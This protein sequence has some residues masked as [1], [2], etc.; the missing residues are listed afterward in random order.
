[1]TE[2]EFLHKNAEFQKNCEKV[3]Q[4][5]D[6]PMLQDDL[7]RLQSTLKEKEEETTLK[8]AVC[9]QYSSGKST[10][11]Q[12]LTKDENIAIGQDITTDAIKIYPWNGVLIADTP[13]IYAGRP[14]HDGLSLDFI[15]KADL[16]IYMIT[17]QGFTREI[18]ANFKSLIQ[19]KYFSK[20]MLL[21]NKRNQEPAENE[22]NW[23]RDTKDFIG[24]E[25]E[26]A[27]LHFTI[28]DIE[29]FATGVRENIPELIAES[30]F[31]EFLQNLNLFIKE[32]ALTGKILSRINIVESFLD[33][34]ITAFSKNQAADEF[35]R[36]Q[37]KIV[38][39]ALSR[40]DRAAS[41][42]SLRIRQQIK[43]LK[44]RLM[45]LLADETLNQFQ[46]E[47][48][49]AELKL[50]EIMNDAQFINDLN[51]IVSELEEALADVD[52]GVTDYE[53]QLKAAAANFNEI[54]V[55]NPI[56]L[57]AFKSGA[58]GLSKLVSS[59]TKDGVLKIVHFFGGKFKPWGATK[60][61]NFVKGLGPWL[62]ALGSVIDIIMFAQDKKHQAEMD[63]ARRSLAESFDEIESGVPA[64]FEAMKQQEN[65]MYAQLTRIQSTLRE[66][67]EKQL[68]EAAR[69]KELV[70][71]LTSINADFTTLKS[72]LS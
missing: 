62:S 70:Q 27:K 19:G 6:E 45:G 31:E 48:E 23:R 54:S 71:I 59:V 21:M 63:H 69:K 5:K 51:Q 68:E 57:T 30:H 7:K 25:E 38:S 66:R 28:V 39:H 29:D 64:Q 26:L 4:L 50:E 61:T 67:I 15:R 32:K 11:V 72:E 2:F 12:V 60:L 18:G 41:E 55:N 20:T 56:D 22:A 17:I 36:R 33:A 13:G 10:L 42:A 14:E 1:M 16:L 52:Q 49:N 43:A 34:Y 65:S 35:S 3:F 8:I 53:N 9:G 44:H 40:Y 58:I 46:L 24:S 37:L 47:L